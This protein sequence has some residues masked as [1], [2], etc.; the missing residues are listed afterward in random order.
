M[1]RPCCGAGSTGWSGP[2]LKPDESAAQ[3]RPQADQSPG[4]IARPTT[5]R[6][7]LAV[8]NL[9]A[10]DLAGARWL[11]LFCG[12]GVMGCEALQRGPPPWWGSSATG[13]W[14]PPPAAIWRRWRSLARSRANPL[15]P[16]GG[17][18]GPGLAGISAGRPL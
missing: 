4:E 11:D 10:P 7:R 1:A 12:S 5:A 9:L 8:M 14:P 15:H 3:W 17:A 2:Q 6:V 16:T 18:G 13:G